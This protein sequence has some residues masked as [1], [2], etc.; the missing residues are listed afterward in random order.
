MEK[1]LKNKKLY[2]LL[3][4]VCV[5][6]LMAALA[7]CTPAATEPEAKD[8]EPTQTVQAP[9]PDEFGVITAA[10]W[11]ET[12]PEIYASYQA[13]L[14][15]SPTADK[16]DYLE[17]YPAAAT[18]YHGFAFEKGY[19]Q[20]ASHLYSL[21]SIGATPRVGDKT[22]T[23]CLT[24]KTPQFTALVNENGDGEYALP[25]AETFPLMTEPISCYN[26][27]ENDPTSLTVTAQ[28]F[29]KGVG[30]DKGQVPEAA[31]SCGQ[32]HNEYYFNPDDKV[33][34]L[35]YSG[36]AAMTPE[37]ILGYYDEIGFKDWEYPEVGS[38]ML[39]VQHPE[40]ETIYGGEQTTMAKMDYSCASCHM[41][42]TETDGVTYTS[43][44]WISPLKNEELLKTCN[45]SGC[46]IDLG[47]QVAE[48]QNT[49]DTRVQSVSLKL[50]DMV[51]KMTAQVEAG[52]LEGEK[53]TELQQLHRSA[54]FYWDFV[55]VENSNGVHN[56]ALAK[57]TLDKAEAA[58]DQAL[59]AL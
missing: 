12:Y 16:H 28:Y 38:P 13:N 49:T 7:A 46:H 17:L 18:L 9:E 56:P 33:V 8:P 50:V 32:C 29:A 55:M 53:L 23:N 25:F 6:A 34:T 10:A 58:V 44:N 30:A 21:D 14:E 31:L 22:L 2:L 39:K 52:T 27:H 42:T 4:V 24:C 45:T 3:S 51:E 57:A 11:E 54:Q 5:I 35:P 59:A 26:C 20:A 40:F 1:A 19:D 37:A 47:A 48:W 41:G 36:L 15:N 43:H